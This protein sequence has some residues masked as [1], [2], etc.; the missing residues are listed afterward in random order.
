MTL[1]VIRRYKS[2]VIEFHLKQ[3]L[4]LSVNRFDDEE[5]EDRF[6]EEIEDRSRLQLPLSGRADRLTEAESAKEKITNE[7][8]H[9]NSVSNQLPTLA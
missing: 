5:I 7:R 1:K 6:D 4:E 8:R 2:S 9:I 3:E